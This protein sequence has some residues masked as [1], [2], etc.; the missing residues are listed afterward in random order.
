MSVI[1]PQLTDTERQVLAM[2]RDPAKSGMGRAVRLSIQY[3][4]GGAVFLYL[5]ID[6][7]NPWY[8]VVIYAIFVAWMIARL[9]GG[10]KLA[11]VMPAIIDKYED[12]I[13]DLEKR[14]SSD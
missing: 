12:R 3:A 7:G 9:L 6:T 4:L 10:K 5:A 14:G 11:G 2:Y 1:D 8:S 13:Q